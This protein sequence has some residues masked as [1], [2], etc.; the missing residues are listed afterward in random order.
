MSTLWLPPGCQEYQCQARAPA[1]HMIFFSV[2][3]F[4]ILGINQTNLKGKWRAQ[5]VVLHAPCPNFRVALLHLFHKLDSPCETIW[6]KWSTFILITTLGLSPYLNWPT[7][8]LSSF[9]WTLL[10]DSL[11]NTNQ[12]TIS[13]DVLTGYRLPGNTSDFTWGRLG[14]EQ[15]S[16]HCTPHIT[17]LLP[18]PSLIIMP[19][20]CI[21]L[22]NS[23]NTFTDFI[24]F[25]PL[26][27]PWRPPGL[28]L[29]FT[30]YR[31]RRL[32]R[33]FTTGFSVEH[34]KMELVSLSWRVVK[35]QTNKCWMEQGL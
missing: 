3:S 29:L 27:S 30:F 26:E 2:Y 24:F 14:G 34:A 6:K 8:F 9:L 20:I 35:K 15:A 28:G 11:G 31:L 10:G 18:H 12:I 17:W 16:W 4:G 22:D 19:W 21:A 5:P 1:L 33:S 7:P 25:D 32:L 23:Q 13:T